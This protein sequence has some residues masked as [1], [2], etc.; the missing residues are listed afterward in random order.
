MT[1]ARG[2]QSFM[3]AVQFLTR[4]PVP[5][6]M[7]RPDPDTT[8]LRSAVVFFPL[9]GAAIGA[10]TGSVIW[11]AASFWP[12]F[13]AVV[14][15]LIVEALLTGAFHEDAVADSCDALGG[16]WSREDVLRILKDSRIG[17][18]GALGLLLGV[19]LRVGGLLTLPAPL[20]VWGCIASAGVG[21]WAILVLMKAVPPIPKRDGLSK[22]VGEQIGWSTV[23]GGTLLTLIAV[24]GCFVQRPVAVI[25]GLLGVFVL[26]L[27]WGIYVR[28]RLDG[29]TGDLLGM[30]CY[31]GQC[32]M[33]L[34]LGGCPR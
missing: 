19:L 21:R 32:V 16:G 10:V 11:I 22:D 20:L 1:L 33:L 28:R 3:T 15:G 4:I 5:G 34:A 7:N 8:L 24:T 13:V 27:L 31:V 26:T 29:V 6:G 2:W 30:I 17:S 25:L 18:Y 14:L 12:L 9:V 23:V